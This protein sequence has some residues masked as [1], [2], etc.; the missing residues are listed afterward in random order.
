MLDDFAAASSAICLAES[1]LCIINDIVTLIVFK[2][3]YIFSY[4][5]HF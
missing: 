3:I 4:T 2:L 1:Q 5:S